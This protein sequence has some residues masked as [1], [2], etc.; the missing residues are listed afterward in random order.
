LRILLKTGRSFAG[1]AAADGGL[2]MAHKTTTSIEGRPQAPNRGI[3][4]GGVV[5]AAGAGK[6]A[7]GGNRLEPEG[8]RGAGLFEHLAGAFIANRICGL[9]SIHN[10]SPEKRHTGTVHRA[11]K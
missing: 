4:G 11:G 5:A 3:S 1:A 8:G 10:G 6:L 2:R 9:S 7:E